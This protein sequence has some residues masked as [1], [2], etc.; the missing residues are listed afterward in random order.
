M[1]DKVKDTLMLW[2]LLGF[3][4]WPEIMVVLT[5]AAIGTLYAMGNK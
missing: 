4:L 1:W 3:A 2:V 5:A